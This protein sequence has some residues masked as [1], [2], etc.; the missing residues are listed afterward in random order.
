MGRSWTRETG[1]DQI[2]WRHSL[3][4]K[5]PSMR[6]YHAFF[7]SI[8]ISFI[9]LAVPG[10]G[11][12]IWDPHS[13][14]EH[15]GPLV[16]AWELLVVVCGIYF[17]NQ[18]S[19]SSLLHWEHGILATG[20]PGKSHH[21]LKGHVLYLSDLPS[22]VPWGRKPLVEFLQIHPSSLKC[23][24]HFLDLSQMLFSFPPL[25]AAVLTSCPDCCNGLEM[26]S[27]THPIAS[28]WLA[29]THLLCC[30]QSCLSRRHRQSQAPLVKPGG[31]SFSS[32]LG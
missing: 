26:D 9:Y 6:S 7:P 15:V 1:S 30:S 27:P 12:I 17:P 25:V 29:L 3:L 31:T 5:P 2:C 13:L 24:F 18:G 23:L 8:F 28:Y 32:P 11:C 4:P 16:I 19:N 21:P 20:P 14:L 10:L 22:L